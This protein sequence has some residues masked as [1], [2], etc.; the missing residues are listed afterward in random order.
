[1]PREQDSQMRAVIFCRDTF[2]GTQMRVPSYLFEPLFAEA[3]PLRFPQ[4]EKSAIG[5]SESPENS[6]DTNACIHQHGVC[7]TDSTKEGS[8]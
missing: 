8:Q 6:N 5:E 2:P 3:E 7:E 1:M 4:N